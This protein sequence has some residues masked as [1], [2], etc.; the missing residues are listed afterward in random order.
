MFLK[1]R[2]LLTMESSVF[3]P[4]STSLYHQIVVQIWARNMLSAYTRIS[5]S[6]ICVPVTIG[7]RRIYQ[8]S[9]FVLLI[10]FCVLFGFSDGSNR[11][12]IVKCW[13]ALSARKMLVH[14][15]SVGRRLIGNV[16]VNRRDRYIKSITT[17]RL[18][19]YNVLQFA[20]RLWV[21]LGSWRVHDAPDMIL[22]LQRAAIRHNL[23]LPLVMLQ[24]N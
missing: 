14:M 7:I 16:W 4:T 21:R 22:L 3:Q 24:R 12:S 6:F 20:L 8:T 2:Q 10:S 23:I 15:H 18:R 11:R 19:N 17:L 9:C 1:V 13:S 5:C